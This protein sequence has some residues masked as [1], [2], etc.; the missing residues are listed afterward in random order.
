MLVFE[1]LARNLPGHCAVVER[2]WLPK[3][4]QGHQGP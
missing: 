2:E 3:L 4:S 1:S